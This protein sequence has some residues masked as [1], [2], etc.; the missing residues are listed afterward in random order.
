METPQ[1]LYAVLVT[2]QNDTLLL[3]GLALAEV[4]SPGGLRPQ[5]HAP[6]W[7]AGILP[8]Q[9]RELPV[10]RFE[11]MNNGAAEPAGRRTRVAVINAIGR[12]LVPQHF[13]LMCEGY[14]RPVTLNRVALRPDEPRTQDSAGLTL[15]RVKVASQLAVIPNLEHIETELARVLAQSAAA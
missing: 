11:L 4:A 8:W 6:P 12:H 10:A 15:C 14:P 9:G 1:Q 5:G 7:F 2:L 13:G 3:P